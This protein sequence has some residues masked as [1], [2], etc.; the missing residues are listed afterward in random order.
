MTTIDTKLCSGT[1][2][3]SSYLQALSRASSGTG[4][5]TPPPPHCMMAWAHPTCIFVSGHEHPGVHGPRG[6]DA[7]ITGLAAGSM[8]PGVGE[9]WLCICPAVFGW[10]GTGKRR[11]PRA[12]DPGR[13]FCCTW[14]SFGSWDCESECWYPGVEMPSPSRER[15]PAMHG[16]GGSTSQNWL[17]LGAGVQQ[18]I[19]GCST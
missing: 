18:L 12:D 1:T 16:A 5:E 15:V 4:S 8:N 6:R 9:K 19:S 7:V 11:H 3:P 2:E 17:N 14:R 10:V 13:Q